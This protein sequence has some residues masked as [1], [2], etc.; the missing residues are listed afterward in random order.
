M[1]SSEDF[2]DA[3]DV[4]LPEKLEKQVALFDRSP[5][6]GVA[7]CRRQ[8]IDE[9]GRESPYRQPALHRG[10]VLAAMFRDNFVCFSSVVVRRRVLE[11]RDGG[12]G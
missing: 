3:D 4:W 10:D 5:T 2:L 12:K 8:L 9:A 7:Y 6:L 11:D 1:R